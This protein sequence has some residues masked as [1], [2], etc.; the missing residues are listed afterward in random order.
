[1]LKN[2]NYGNLKGI[3]ELGHTVALLKPVLGN[4]S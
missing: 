1:V 2:P 4:Y 3:I